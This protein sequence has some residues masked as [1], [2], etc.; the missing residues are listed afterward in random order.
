MIWWTMLLVVAYMIYKFFIALNKDNKDL[1]EK[2][3]T[4]RFSVLIETLNNSVYF[5]EG[6]LRE[7][8]ERSFNLYNTKTNTILMFFYSTG[9]LTITW[10]KNSL[11][12]G[13]RTFE[14]QFND[15]RNIDI[16]TQRLMANQ[17]FNEGEAY[18]KPFG[19]SGIIKS[20]DVEENQFSSTKKLFSTVSNKQKMSILNAMLLVY[21][22]KVN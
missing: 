12:G 18:F 11:R 9:H 20:D 16:M 17:F 14:K 1:R 10:K 21:V 13:D 19:L 22:F 3:L 4:E 2:R 15:V 8:D 6:A 7:I 5:G